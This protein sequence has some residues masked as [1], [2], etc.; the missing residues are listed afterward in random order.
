MQRMEES[1]SKRPPHL[2]IV[3]TAIVAALMAG[4]GVWLGSSM[5]VRH[6][7]VQCGGGLGWIGPGLTALY[8]LVASTLFTLVTV[9]LALGIALPRRRWGW[10][11]AFVAG[12]TE[13]SS[14]A[15]HTAVGFIFDAGC[16]WFYPIVI[17]H[18]SVLFVA[19]FALVSPL[20]E[21]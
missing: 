2:G 13:S 5:Y 6:N 20:V 17:E 18:G 4:I 15:A 1:M 12:L 11:G 9:V 8:V 14:D 3:V 7:Q 19:L 21:T 16:S 10:S